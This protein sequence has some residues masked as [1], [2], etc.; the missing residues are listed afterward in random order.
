M[1]KTTTMRK[2]F[3]AL[4]LSHKRSDKMYTI[5]SLKKH[6]YSGDF[7]IVL[8]SDDPTI[9]KYIE[10]F[11][12][13]K[14]YIFDKD[15]MEERFDTMGTFGNRKTI[16]YAR[17]KCFD[18]A[19]ELGYKYFIQLDD[20]Y[21]DWRYRVDKKVYNRTSFRIWD[22]DVVF[23]EMVDFLEKTPRITS[24][25]LSQGGDHFGGYEENVSIKRKAM[26]S[27][28]CDVDRP[29]EFYGNINEDVNT[30]VSEGNKG[31]LFLT[32]WN[33]QLDQKSTQQNAGGMTDIYLE[34]GTYLKSFYSVMIAPYCVTLKSMGS[35]NPRIHHAIDWQYAVPYIIQEK[36]KKK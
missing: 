33:L 34:S 22:L 27:F 36:H 18:I 24:L 13:D 6:G 12:K 2:D 28:I 21:D 5:A 8:S 4:I 26:N 1:K 25:C 23:N 20:D 17:N 29:F 19:N 14:I 11:G 9:D 7:I 30:Y 3:V 32:I 15:E 31:K 10:K 16:F 35:T